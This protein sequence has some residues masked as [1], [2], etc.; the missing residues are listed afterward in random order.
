MRARMPR[1]SKTTPMRVRTCDSA[2]PARARWS[3][4]RGHLLPVLI[5]N[6]RGVGE[7]ADEG[8]AVVEQERHGI[9]RMTGSRNDLSGKIQFLEK[10]ATLGEGEQGVV[11]RRDVEIIVFRLDVVLH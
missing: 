5:G 8:A 1:T 4:H 10:C 2:R 11:V 6:E 7:I 3:P 9:R